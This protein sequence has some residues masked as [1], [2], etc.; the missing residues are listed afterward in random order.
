MD[1]TYL[2][3]SLCYFEKSSHNNYSLT[4][5]KIGFTE[6]ERIVK[7]FGSEFDSVTRSCRIQFDITTTGGLN[8]LKILNTVDGS[9]SDNSSE[10]S[11]S[12]VRSVKLSYHK[13]VAETTEPIQTITDKAALIMLEELVQSD[14]TSTIIQSEIDGGKTRKMP[15]NRKNVSKNNRNRSENQKTV[16]DC[17]QN[18][19]KMPEKQQIQDEISSRASTII[20]S[21]IDN[22]KTRIQMNNRFKKNF[23]R[24]KFGSHIPAGHECDLKTF[25]KLNS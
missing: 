18:L 11:Q 23:N 20:C 21:E 9:L 16:T 25:E 5:L 2:Q 15:I 24:R 14:T 12:T 7:K 4:K 22:G 17:V 3:F 13:A 6:I 1:V 19:S 8:N 10:I